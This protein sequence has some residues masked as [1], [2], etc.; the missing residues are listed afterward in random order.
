MTRAAR[1]RLRPA[2]NN[3]RTSVRW[4]IYLGIASVLALA[5]GYLGVGLL[6]ATRLS[7][8][9]PETIGPPPEGLAVEEVA[10]DATDGV[11]LSAWWTTPPSDKDPRRAAVLV[12]GWGGNRSDEYIKKTAPLYAE[13]GYAVL[14]LDLRG[15]GESGG[16]RRTLGYAEVRDV[17]GALAWLRRR[18]FEP[19]D[20]VLHGWSMGGATVV[21]SAPGAGVAAVVE[22]AGYADLPLLLRD[23]LPENSGLPR[24][25]NP[26]AFLTAKLFLG[27]DPW[28]VRPREDAARL[29]REGVPLFVIHSTTDETVPYEH[30]RLFARANPDAERWTLEGYDHVGA[31]E[32]P[33]Y[34]EKLGFFLASLPAREPVEARR[35]AGVS[36]PRRTP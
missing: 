15:H 17:R 10:L 19:G 33:E 26:A 25:F 12:H 5:V 7:A 9:S 32:S 24:I 29:Q 27:F 36:G 6:V 28:A 35:P 4:A 18:G 11:P 16:E 8:P 21:R 30:A 31:Y 3:L 23:Q 2:A 1:P 13:A 22:E 20:V 34:A 14:M